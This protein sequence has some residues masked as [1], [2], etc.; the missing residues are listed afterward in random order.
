MS[1]FKM[2]KYW[3]DKTSLEFQELG[4]YENKKILK[5]NIA[6]HQFEVLDKRNDKLSE[7]LL[8]SFGI[9]L[10]LNDFQNHKNIGFY[11][12]E[13]AE[14]NFVGGNEFN[15]K[16]SFL[17]FNDLEIVKKNKIV[18]RLELRCSDL[19]RLINLKRFKDTFERKFSKRYKTLKLHGVS[20][21]NYVKYLNLLIFIIN[22]NISYE[23]NG[24]G[25]KKA[26]YFIMLNSVKWK[27]HNYVQQMKPI[28]REFKIK[29]TN[30]FPFL[31]F[32]Q[33]S[34][35]HNDILSETLFLSK[36]FESINSEFVEEGFQNDIL[37]LRNYLIH[38]EREENLILSLSKKEYEILEKLRRV[39]LE[40]L[41]LLNGN[42]Y[43][44]AGSFSL[45]N[46]KTKQ[47][48]GLYEF[49]DSK[50]EGN[51]GFRFNDYD[52]SF[53]EEYYEIERKFY[54]RTGIFRFRYDS[55][56][57]RAYFSD[58]S[59]DDFILDVHEAIIFFATSIVESDMMIELGRF[60][61]ICFN[62]VESFEEFD[63]V[64]YTNLHNWSSENESDLI[65]L[66]RFNDA[67][68][69]KNNCQFEEYYLFIER[70][71]KNDSEDNSHSNNL[72]I[73]FMINY[74]NFSKSVQEKLRSHYG[75]LPESHNIAN[76]F[77]NYRNMC[78]HG[79]NSKEEITDLRD[80]VVWLDEERFIM[81]MVARE[82]CIQIINKL[83][84]RALN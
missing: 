63:K 56:Q 62:D 46:Y 2:F 25:E 79:V 65:F 74:R 78:F 36:F 75:E 80:G 37:N 50:K 1:G 30:P 84:K 42:L 24:I 20:K 72:R 81:T 17:E 54:G 4:C 14:F 55:L 13:Y 51:I 76:Y 19:F 64:K 70:F 21:D 69:V 5:D 44:S 10:N 39:R 29:P 61:S 83:N 11:M 12:D 8:E 82:L 34:D 27:S 26:G 16:D 66:N 7:N 68:V 73:L 22:K 47:L 43:D 57:K 52:D 45:I 9:I 41:R 38:E 15:F 58:T 60:P 53:E 3:T 67:L 77:A 31:Y 35:W 18:A 33:S 6:N 59:E 40:A 23:N 71:F 48:K 32:I 49:D 28:G